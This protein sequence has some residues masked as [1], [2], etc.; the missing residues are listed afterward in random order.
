M[1]LA[2]PQNAYP[3]LFALLI[4]LISFS[5]FWGFYHQ[6]ILTDIKIHLDKVIGVIEGKMNLGANFLY[7]LILYLAAMVVGADPANLYL[8]AAFLLA[9]AVSAKYLLTHKFLAKFGGGGASTSGYRSFLA[10]ALIFVFSIPIVKAF[11]GYYYRGSLPPNVWHNSTTIFL[12][13][14]ALLLFWQSYEQ[15]VDPTNKRIAWLA[16]LVVLNIVIKPSYCFVF[17]V[18][19]PLF[20]WKRFRFSKDFWLNLIPIFVAV[21]LVAAQH[22]L[23]FELGLSK[24]GFD[25]ASR[26]KIAPF[27]VWSSASPNIPVS[28]FGTLLFPIIY[29]F[30][31]F[32]E[33]R[34]DLLI[35]YT[36]FGHLVALAIY[37]LFMETGDRQFHGNFG[38]QGMV[39]AYT[40][41][42]AVA[43][44]FIKNLTGSDTEGNGGLA[45][46]SGKNKVIL[47]FFGL[48][49]I[50]GLIYIVKI[51]TLRSFA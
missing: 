43:S 1:N 42:L 17:I 31:Y 24:T 49:L 21:G 32:K 47:A 36:V 15:L 34:R 23:I 12:M 38:W 51:F 2:R 30:F 18:A 48:H 45:A 6:G 4:F 9:S 33:A 16:L 29:I 40:L 28:L 7:F 27:K 13:P 50:S 25:D 39:T 14:F 26:V 3:F 44:L 41:F 5:I 46:L 20:L 35:Q 11:G 19:Y 37:A 22:F 10:V 8:A